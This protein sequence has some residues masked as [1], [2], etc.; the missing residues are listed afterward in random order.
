MTSENTYNPT[1][2]TWFLVTE[3]HVHKLYKLANCAY[4]TKEIKIGST[5]HIYERERNSKGFQISIQ[6]NAQINI[7]ILNFGA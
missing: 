4:N 3:E 7:Q 1:S 5:E 2:H 6:L